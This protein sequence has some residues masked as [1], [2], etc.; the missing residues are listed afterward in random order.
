M[1]KINL[2]SRTMKKILLSAVILLVAGLGTANAQPWTF[3][4]KVGATFSTANGVPQAKVRAGVVAGIF[5]ESMVSDWYAIQAEILYTQQGYDMKPD[6]GSK[7]KNR[8]DYI[9]M[10]VVNKF[11]LIGGLNFQLGAQFAYLLDAKKIKEDEHSNI[12]GNFNKFDVQFV[13]GLAYDFDFGLV[14]EGRYQIGLT[15]LTSTSTDGI[16]SGT[17][18]ITAGWKF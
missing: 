7:L 18:Q 11:Y 16:T 15:R 8:L 5:A 2:K 1:P 6:G 14:I 12:R 4:P 10:P 9:A 13:T 17:L 3:G